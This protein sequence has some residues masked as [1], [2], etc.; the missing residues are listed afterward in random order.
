[1]FTFCR[2]TR[3]KIVRKTDLAVGGEMELVFRSSCIG[4]SV[5][6][7]NRPCRRVP[8]RTH[9][10]PSRDEWCSLGEKI[11]L[12]T[13]LFR[14]SAHFCAQS[15]AMPRARFSTH[16]RDISF[17]NKENCLDWATGTREIISSYIANSIVLIFT[18]LAYDF[19]I[20]AFVITNE[21]ERSR[22][23]IR[24]IVIW[25]HIYR[26]FAAVLEI[27]KIK[28]FEAFNM[29]FHCASPSA[30]KLLSLVYL[31]KYISTCCG[32]LAGFRTL[33]CGRHQHDRFDSPWPNFSK[34]FY[35]Q[36]Y[37]LLHCSL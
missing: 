36:Q 16:F 19:K 18:R 24:S 15:G 25:S 31:P 34:N 28:W 27:L 13:Q 23:S 37:C 3:V 2:Y 22:Y 29:R 9:I 20:R 4:S 8:R 10:S 1:M 21:F 7:P 6:R 33:R 30:L 35:T 32:S 12:E 11:W 14:E 17:T 5:A 26:A